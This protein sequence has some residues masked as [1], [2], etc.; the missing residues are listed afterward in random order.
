MRTPRTRLMKLS[1]RG[2]LHFRNK[3]TFLTLSPRGKKH[4]TLD[5]SDEQ[6]E[7]F[8]MTPASFERLFSLW[9][10]SP[11]F[12]ASAREM[13]W[14]FFP[15]ALIQRNLPRLSVFRHGGWSSTIPE[16][17]G[18]A[19][20]SWLSEHNG[21]KLSYY[22]SVLSKGKGSC[23]AERPRKTL[24]LILLKGVGLPSQILFS[25]VC[26]VRM[27]GKR[28]AGEEVTVNGFRNRDIIGYPL[29]NNTLSH[30]H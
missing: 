25:I 6:R 26:H 11:C 28:R 24:V 2:M 9:A 27:E 5:M 15:A 30:T 21:W 19:V 17:S 13:F 29:S 22:L 23:G 7:M 14:V 20:I 16:A 10:A 8:C 12:F 4:R 1:P 18:S 3:F